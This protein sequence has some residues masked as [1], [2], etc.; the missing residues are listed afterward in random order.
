[1]PSP[2]SDPWAYER[3]ALARRR[4]R[5]RRQRQMLW[6]LTGVTTAVLF[7]IAWMIK[8]IAP[9]PT[10]ARTAALSASARASAPARAP[11]RPAVP[12]DARSTAKAR[13]GAS[14]SPTV[15]RPRVTDD[16]SGLSYRLISR[17]W[18]RGCPPVLQ[19]PMFNWSAGE[20]AVAGHVIIGGSTIEWHASACSGQLQQQFAYTGPADLETTAMSLVGALDPAY[21]SGVQHDLTV[22]GSSPMMVSGDQAWVVRFAVNY[23]NGVS[24]GL[25]WTSELG[26]VVIVDRGPGYVPALFYVSVPGNVDTTDVDTLIRS[27]RVG[28]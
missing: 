6:L 16:T 18:R 27:L 4:R 10:A 20:N 17:P 3:R 8:E 13:P 11:V 2:G 12:G 23:L 5:Q 15:S 14:P 25:T 9:V 28:R 19:T 22:S 24:Q 26:A 1:M 7:V 21:Y